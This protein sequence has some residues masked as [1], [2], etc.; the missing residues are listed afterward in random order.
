MKVIKKVVACLILM[1]LSTPFI[2]LIGLNNSVEARYI[3]VNSNTTS[4]IS[5]KINSNETVRYDHAEYRYDVHYKRTF[6]VK[7]WE[8]DLDYFTIGKTFSCTKKNNNSPL[9]EVKITNIVKI[10]S[11]VQKKNNGE[12]VQNYLSGTKMN[13]WSCS[14]TV[15]GVYTEEYYHTGRRN[16]NDFSSSEFYFSSQFYNIKETI[17]PVSVTEHVKYIYEVTTVPNTGNNDSNILQGIKSERNQMIQSA[18]NAANNAANSTW[19]ST[20][21]VTAPSAS[22]PTIAEEIINLDTPK[23]WLYIRGLYVNVLGRE[24]EINE[25]ISH[26][27]DTC[28]HNAYNIIFSEESQNRNKISSMSNENYVRALYKYILRRNADDGGVTTY[29]Q[30]LN[31]GNTRENLITLLINS[32]EFKEMVNSEVQTLNFK[33]SNNCKTVYEYLKKNNYNVVKPADNYLYVYKKEIANVKTISGKSLNDLMNQSSTNSVRV[34]KKIDASTESKYIYIRGIFKNVLGRET[35]FDDIKKRS[36]NSYEKIAYDIILSPESKKNNKIESISNEEYVKCLY[37][38]ILRREGDS[39]G[40]QTHVKWL[41]AGNSRGDLIYLLI[42]SQEFENMVKNQVDTITFGNSQT[43]DAVYN[44]LKNNGYNIVKPENNKI[45]MYKKEIQNVKTLDISGKSLT[46][47]TGISSFSNIESLFVQNNKISNV[48]EISKLTKLKTLQLSNNGEKINLNN[49]EKL[50]NLTCLYLNNNGLTTSDITG[51][52]KL[53]N[54]QQLYLNSNN[55]TSLSSIENLSNLIELYL[56]D[57]N[58]DYIGNISN[59]KT[60]FIRIKNNITQITTANTTVSLPDLFQKAITQNSTVYTSDNLECVNCKIENNN[61]IIN[62]DEK[63]ATITI[64]SGNAQG[65]KFII[66]NNAEIISCNDKVL[67]DRLQNKLSK[68][69]VSRI[70]EGG[71]YKLYIS[72]ERLNAI[73]LLDLSATNTDTAKITDITGLEKFTNLKTLCLNNNNVKNLD[74]L[75]D[76][77]KLRTLNIRHNGLTNLNGIKNLT[78]LIQLDASNNSISDISGISGLTNLNTVVLSNN[79]IGNNLKPLSSL[80]NLTYLAISNNSI[81]DVSSLSSL[82]LSG[83]YLSYNQI[84]DIS[85]INKEELED[86]NVENNNVTISAENSEVELPG[87]VKNSIEQNG[88]TDNLECINCSINNN[89][90]ILNDGAKTAQIK[91]KSG[92]F[93]DTIVNFTTIGDTTPPNLSVDYELSSDK[94]SMR[95]IITA[96][97]RIK[98]VF[99]W[100]WGLGNKIYKDFKYNVS[101]QY[102]LVKDLWGN[103]TKQLINFTGIE[104]NKIAD[105]SVDYSE[106]M[107]TNGDVTVTITSSENLRKTTG[108]TLSSDKKSLTR[109]FTENT[110]RIIANVL[111]ERMFNIQMQPEMV[112]IQISNIDKD[113]PTYSIEYST[114]S[115]TKSSVIATIWSDEDIALTNNSSNFINKTTKVDENGKVKYGISLYYAENTEDKVTICDLAKNTTIVPIKIDNID[116]GV[117]GLYTSLDSTSNTNKNVTLT[118]GANEKITTKSDEAGSVSKNDNG[119]YIRNSVL[120]S[121]VS[122]LCEI[123]MNNVVEIAGN[124]SVTPIMDGYVEQVNSKP[125]LYLSYISDK[126][127][128]MVSETSAK[129]VSDNQIELEITENIEGIALLEDEAGNLDAALINVST[130]DTIPPTALRLED[131]ENDDGTITVTLKLGESISSD[132]GLMDW[133]YDEDNLT[134]TKTFSKNKTETLQLTDLAGNTSDFEVAVTDIAGIDYQLFYEYD[135]KSNKVVAVI[136]SNTELKEIEGWSISKDKKIIAKAFD[137]DQDDEITLEDYSGNT[138]NVQINTRFNDLGNNEDDEN[139]EEQ[140]I[141]DTQANKEFPQTGKYFICTYVISILL[142]GATFVVLNWDK[143]RNRK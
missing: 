58:V 52:S 30:W 54:L 26:D 21:A 48:D 93:S 67:A 139:K 131:V 9:K 1:V 143:I 92:N 132:N 65:S 72:K 63:T 13:L 133:E 119:K 81:S 135:K 35:S 49:I 36:A 44:H 136:E 98:N 116:N 100:D 28:M 46:D 56:N 88:G 122:K 134:L 118:I 64:K 94:T 59:S 110:D 111:T 102:V 22:A 47:L 61:V 4:E 137:L 12:I 62:P 23:K 37:R 68:V 40:I 20:P 14:M 80:S 90:A 130:I 140:I 19:S 24:P 25:I 55:I 78:N 51:L 73:Q 138:V 115:K 17:S 57:N 107:P 109:T 70:D 77:K 15:E 123:K 66:T 87:I 85:A 120:G 113:A 2:E 95:V 71:K 82:K 79:I 86:L 125:M 108:W 3:A 34:E 10:S 128:F 8:D 112:D 38:W 5:S 33:N 42:H 83:V 32:P 74:K 141:D 50:T 114:T 7:I 6:P 76:L 127:V 126:P 53:T 27:K 117:D 129:P 103:E 84:S 75:S 106:T 142:I 18:I 104:N 91:I 99:G 89:K 105:L 101:D 31:N 121:A 11:E 29:T 16:K 69:I 45:Y 39:G 124:I 60:Q 41:E 97:E 96:D 43:C